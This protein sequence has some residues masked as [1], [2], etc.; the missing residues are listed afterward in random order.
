MEPNRQLIEQVKEIFSQVRDVP[1]GEERDKLIAEACGDDLD[2][3]KEVESLLDVYGSTNDFLNCDAAGGALTDSANLVG[4]V[5]D[6]YHL[7]EHIGEGG[8]G[9][10]Y[11]AEQT[12]PFKREVALKIIKLGM[13]TKN[14]I[15]RFGAERQALARM[16]HPGIAQV[17]DAGITETGRP[18]F[19]M[20]L[21]HGIPFIDYCD[22]NRLPLADRLDLFRR[23]CE[24]VQHAHQKGILHRDLK[25]SNILVCED[26]GAPMPKIID[27]G[28][29]KS[30]EGRLTEQTLAT[31]QE[32]L[33]GTPMYMSPEQL[34]SDV[35]DIDTRSDIYSLGIILYELVAGT[36][37]LE[38][39][40]PSPLTIAE[41][42]KALFEKEMPRPSRRLHSMGHETTTI[43]NARQI[44]PPTLER[45][46]RGDLDW[47]VMKAI[48]KER[49][50][51]Y[52]DVGALAQDLER[53]ANHEPVS[54][55]PPRVAY[56]LKKFIRRHR[57]ASVVVVAVGSA[58]LLGA[59]VSTI[60]FLRAS[61]EAV[62]AR[63]QEAIAETTYAFLADELLSR[64]DPSA[65]PNRD[66]KLRTVVDRAAES[67]EQHF[68]EQ[69]LVC[70]RIHRLLSSIYYSLGEYPVALA[71]AEE[72]MRLTE[73]HL[74]NPEH[75]EQM[76][77]MDSLATALYGAE[78]DRE[79]EEIHR[80][81]LAIQVRVLGSEHPD[82]LHSLMGLAHVCL[83]QGQVDEAEKLIREVL[84]TRQRTL[85][86]EHPATLSSMDSLGNLLKR[87]GKLKTSEKIYRDI[88][89]TEQ[90][91]L[92]L[93]HPETMDSMHGL[94]SVLLDKGGLKEAE[95]I[96][97]DALDARQRIL[98]P[99]HPDT[100]HSMNNLGVVL[101]RRGS[102]Q[103]AE[104][105]FR[106]LLNLRQ[107]VNGMGHPDTLVASYNLA[108]AVRRPGRKRESEKIL[109][110]AVRISLDE[111]AAVDARDWEARHDQT[112]RRL[113]SIG[114]WN[115]DEEVEQACRQLLEIR[116][117]I[118]GPEHPD[119]LNN[120]HGLACALRVLEKYE[121]A[122]QISRR[123]L[124]ILRQTE[125]NEG[126][127][128]R[129]MMDLAIVL[130]HL[131][132]L[133]E[134]E[135]ICREALGI[136]ERIAPPDERHRIDTMHH[137]AF[138]LSDQGKHTEAVKICRD[139]VE[140][141]DRLTGV[142]N[143]QA[144]PNAEQR[145]TFFAYYQLAKVLF[146]RGSY[147]E[148]ERMCRQTYE[149]QRKRLSKHHPHTLETGKLLADIL[150]A[151]D[152]LPE[153]ER[154]DQEI[155]ELEEWKKTR[156]N[157]P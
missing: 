10:V 47:V 9:E 156:E 85:G 12:R 66:I 152:R 137:L 71:H 99:E 117:R 135:T 114:M 64:A 22:R 110:D 13:D 131:G 147:E 54:A 26:N 36:T 29:A 150:R 45:L 76:A 1:A 88:L 52:D 126:L 69:P 44:K 65:E 97:R 6:E 155:H 33:I 130:R 146:A 98:G 129:A 128:V 83:V 37:P 2:L 7:V 63:E 154:L 43:A 34:D 115:A 50:R 149:Q 96:L 107:R 157:T 105:V 3:R 140:V 108:L 121:E 14:V 27:F 106:D 39:E 51:R 73:A 70:A 144:F 17:Y 30:L 31:L 67:L 21:V 94:G 93:D 89:A 81:L 49:D 134:A 11:R 57:M 111:L 62:R 145:Q 141:R 59:I 41:M 38:G 24:A 28:V 46:L 18:Y 103:E 138:I 53:Y 35:A 101:L 143:E 133:E 95:T 80:K 16:N 124:E 75:P 55:G 74:D 104:K 148:A 78:R 142:G 127:A 90:Y 122:E 100:L 25:P 136:Q 20:E 139:V 153:S 58:L 82:T 86:P 132:Q 123:E 48:E 40:L 8:F 92:G 102:K 91:V 112:L 120:M 15:A 56:R 77:S 61:R 42:Q 68:M 32:M 109:M 72:A 113:D 5:I 79:S 119:T 60:G 19:V 125:W 151:Q 4:T 23:A 118:L 84:K 116:E 87:R